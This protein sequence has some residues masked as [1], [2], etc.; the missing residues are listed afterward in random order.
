MTNK[1]EFQLQ[2]SFQLKRKDKSHEQ[3]I[4]SKIKKLCSKINSKE[5]YYTTSSCSG[6][7]TLI[8][9]LKEKSK[10]VF[11]F[12]THT[13]I[14]FFELKKELQKAIKE[15]PNMI[16]FKQESCILHV[17]CKDFTS[18]E[19]LLIKAR[20]AGWKRSGIIASKKR[21]VLEL[22]STERLELPIANKKKILVNDDF[23]KLLAKE[24]NQRLNRVE[25][26]IKKFEGLI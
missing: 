7:I 17:V 15:Y 12:K 14:S 23:L 5:E 13:K 8:K 11:L 20:I 24:A 10:N 4:D 26:K 18:A 21:I 6:R 2:K 25:K 1:K 16:Y 9:A 3:K 19:K 22:M